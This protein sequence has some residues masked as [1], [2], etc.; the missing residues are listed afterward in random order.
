MSLR[1][2]DLRKAAWERFLLEDAWMLIDDVGYGIVDVEHP[3]VINCGIAEWSMVGM[4]AGMASEGAKV[5]CYH[6]A[7]HILRAWEFVRNVIVPRKLNVTFLAIGE[8]EDYKS[9]GFSHVIGNDELRDM[10]IA[11]DLPYN[12]VQ[13]NNRL[14]YEWVHPGPKML[15]ITK[16]KA[17]DA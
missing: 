10:C 15:Q 13:T 11:I 6:I 1:Q 8:G 12:Y 4:A 17:T 3:R 2:P 14:E 16:R 7:P 9:L 5:Y